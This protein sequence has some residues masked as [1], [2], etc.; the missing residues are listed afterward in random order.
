MVDHRAVSLGRVEGRD[1]FREILA[2]LAE[3]I[4]DVRVRAVEICRINE[5]TVLFR[6]VR[7]GTNA[8]GGHV[9]VASYQLGVVRDG[10]CR[11]IE[12]FPLEERAAALARFDELSADSDSAD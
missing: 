10:L 2:H 5:T 7:T 4:P 11:R 8:E 6:R 12:E 9:E 3:V 1:A